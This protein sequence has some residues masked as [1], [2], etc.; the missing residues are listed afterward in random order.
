MYLARDKRQRRRDQKKQNKTNKQKN[1]TKQN[2]KKTK[3]KTKQNNNNPTWFV[4]LKN[5]QR[6]ACLSAC[7]MI[8]P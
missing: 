8:S 5:K 2:K 6:N 4:S 7:Q 3:N 1:K